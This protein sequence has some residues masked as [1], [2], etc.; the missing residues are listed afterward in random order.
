MELNKRHILQI[1]QINCKEKVG[2][3]LKDYNRKDKSWKKSIKNKDYKDER[4][5]N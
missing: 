3:S 2:K 4:L 1:I 5:D